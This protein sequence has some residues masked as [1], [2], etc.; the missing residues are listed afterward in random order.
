MLVQTVTATTTAD[1]TATPRRPGNKGTSER[2]LVK[3]WAK[4]RALDDARATG[5]ERRSGQRRHHYGDLRLSC[6]HSQAS[7]LGVVDRGEVVDEASQRK[8]F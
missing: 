7:G 2:V 3:R 8:S 1:V 4:Q 5:K 6:T